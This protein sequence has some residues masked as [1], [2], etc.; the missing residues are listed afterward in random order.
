MRNLQRP[1]TSGGIKYPNPIIYS[2]LFYISNLFEYFKTR[3]NDLPFNSNT[4]LIEYE[5]GFVLSQ[6]YNLPILNHIPHR[7][8]PTPYYQKTLQI[9]KEYKITLE[10]LNKEKIKQ[11]YYRISY[12]NK[13]HSHQEFFRWKLV[14]QNILPN[15]LNTFNYRTVRHFL[16]FSPEPGECVL[17][18]QLQDSAVYVFAKCS[19]T[20]QIWTILK[21]SLTTSLKHLSHS[22]TLHPLISTTQ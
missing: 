2:N 4:Y 17:C 14:N 15:Y 7:D 11:I 18:L 16:P 20:R 21:K 5:I 8:Y 3:K 1:T 9:L 19:I 6:T 13:R 10:E 22:I 12:P